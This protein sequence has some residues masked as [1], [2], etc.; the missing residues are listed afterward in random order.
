[1]FVD[2]DVTVLRAAKR[3]FV[4]RGHAVELSQSATEAR[5]KAGPFDCVIL[6]ID[7]ASESGLV[8]AQE[9]P[10]SR[11]SC[12]VFYSGTTDPEVRLRAT[13][14]GTF[15]SKE[16]GLHT[17]ARVVES[18]VEEAEELARAAGGERGIVGASSN[19]RMESGFR[20]KR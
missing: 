6:D 19:P 7:L 18:V 17:L 10:T 8:L 11:A 16:G 14:L 20:K 15:V 5:A 13:E 2:D 1:M 4:H 3:Y 12:I 9:F